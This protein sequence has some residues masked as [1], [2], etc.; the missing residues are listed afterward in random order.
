MLN[1]LFLLFFEGQRHHLLTNSACQK[2]GIEK[3]VLVARTNEVE[4]CV[5]NRGSDGAHML[6]SMVLNAPDRQYGC[7]HK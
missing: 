4:M 7:A 3:M 2:L 1:L 6:R 5:F